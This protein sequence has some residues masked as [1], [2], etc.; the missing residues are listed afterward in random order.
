MGKM[1]IE[2]TEERIERDDGQPD[3]TVFTLAGRRRTAYHDSTDCHAMRWESHE[4][5][6]TTRSEAQAALRYPC[7]GCV[8]GNGNGPSSKGGS[9]ERPETR[10][11]ALIERDRRRRPAHPDSD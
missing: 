11:A 8:L 1:S 6:E 3:D 7:G 4:I 2:D 10:F 5:A 9:F